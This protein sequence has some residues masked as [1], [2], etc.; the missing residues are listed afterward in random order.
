MEG[1]THMDVL[2]SFGYYDVVMTF[3]ILHTTV[4]IPVFT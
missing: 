2:Y 1:F 4:V 3:S